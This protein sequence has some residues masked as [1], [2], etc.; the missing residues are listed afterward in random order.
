MRRTGKISLLRFIYGK[1]SSENKLFLDLKNPLNQQ[2]FDEPNYEKIKS[3]LEILELKFNKKPYLFL[4]EIQ[5]I[6][7]LPFVIKYLIDHYK[8]KCFLTGSASF[9]LKN[10]FSES[11]SGRKYLFELFPLTFKE[12]LFFFLFSNGNNRIRRF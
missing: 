12:F 1:I 7:N 9:Y 6:K 5:L 11:L 3:N 8:I 10:L 2:Y 4:D